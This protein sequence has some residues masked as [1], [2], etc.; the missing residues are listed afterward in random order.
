MTSCK[1]INT[2]GKK[3]RTVFDVRIEFEDYERNQIIKDLRNSV[4]KFTNDLADII[5]KG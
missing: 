2:E 5:E 1:E 4:W 3:K